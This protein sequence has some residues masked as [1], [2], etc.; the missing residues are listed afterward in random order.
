MVGTVPLSCQGTERGVGGSIYYHSNYLAVTNERYLKVSK[1]LSLFTSW[2]FYITKVKNH[3][4]AQEEET[5][6]F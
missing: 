3:L 5:P 6:T 4:K 1:K 2:L